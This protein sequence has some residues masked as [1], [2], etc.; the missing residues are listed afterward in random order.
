MP[1]LFTGLQ[2]PGSICQELSLL[3]GGLNGAKWIEPESYHL[4]LRFIGDVDVALANDILDELART[5]CPQVT[6]A[7]DGLIEFGGNKP[8]AI[9]VRVQSDSRLIDLQ[10]GQERAIRRA[11][12]APETRKFIPHVT[13]ARLRSVSPLAVADYLGSRTAFKPLTFKAE[14]FVVYSSRASRGG[15]PYVVEA[16][17]PLG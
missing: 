10:A 12:A 17:Y 13:L 1:R 5:S 3:R 16:A 11:G 15:G 6:I 14:Q 9:A 4:T 2:I 8:R 7:L